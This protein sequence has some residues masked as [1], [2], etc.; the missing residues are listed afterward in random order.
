MNTKQTTPALVTHDLTK[1]YGGRAAVDNLSIEVPAGVVAGFIGPNGAGK[2]TTM[3]ML[4]G[5]VSADGRERN[6]PRLEPRR[7]GLLPRPRRRAD[8]DARLL[9]GPDRDREPPRSGD[10]R[11]PRPGA[12]SPR[13][14]DLVG[15]DG[16]GGDR[17]GEY[18]LGMKQRLGIAAALLGDP[19]LLVLDEPTN[20]LDPAGINEMRQFILELADG[21]RTVLV[22][23]HILSELE[24]V[25]RLADRHQRR[26]AALPGPGRRVPR[27]GADGDRARPGASRRPR[28]AGRAG[29]RRTDTSPRRDDGELIVPVDERRRQSRG[30]GAEQGRGRAGD[31]PRGAAHAPAEPRV[32]VPRRD[33]R[34]TMIAA[35]RAEL[36]KVLRRRV[37][38]ITAVTDRRVR[39]RF[40]RRRPRLRRT[41]RQRVSGRGVTVA[42]LSDAGGGTEVFT[43]AVSFAGTF[44]F[45]LFVGVVA[46]EFSRGTFRT[47]LLHQPRRLRLLAGKMARPCSRSRRSCSRSTEALTW[48]AAG[49]SRPRRTSRPARGSAPTRSARLL[50]TTAPSLF[51]V[52]GYAL[53]GTTLAVLV[54]SVPVALAIGIAWAGPFEHLLQD[55]WGPASGSSRGYC[56]RPSSPAG[57]Q[58]V[59][60]TQRLPHGCRLRRRSPRR[61]PRRV[62]AR[63]DVTA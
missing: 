32:P 53:L 24:H 34:R 1:R 57:R 61:S 59:S 50:P 31:R 11:R 4:L 36:V 23:S 10:A 25:C 62:F 56:S 55:A 20:G 9:A 52:S 27:T 22:S 35:L 46:V 3:A 18:S 13:C 58:T 43:T 42:S 40:R 51:W 5:L 16:R 14:S 39:R 21:E 2:T 8:R 47:M 41:R 33:R 29:P 60:A 26:L 15:L 44:L 37:L 63:R 28:P 48:M 45:V 38:V 19:E 17:F 30:R 7:P 12:A 49:C 54:R 6:R